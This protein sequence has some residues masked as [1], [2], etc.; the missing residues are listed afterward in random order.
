MWYFLTLYHGR[1]C[2][3]CV[4]QRTQDVMSLPSIARYFYFLALFKNV[5]AF[6]TYDLVTYIKVKEHQS[7]KKNNPGTSRLVSLTISSLCSH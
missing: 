1:D 7:G 2:K 6:S 5:C 3:R 4:D